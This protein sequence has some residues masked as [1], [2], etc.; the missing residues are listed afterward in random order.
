MA[1]PAFSIRPL[2]DNDLPAVLDVYRGCEDFLAL[3]PVATASLAMVQQDIAQS[4]EMGGTFCGI[5]APDEIMLGVVDYVLSGFECDPRHAFIS[6]LMIA[7]P[8]RNMGLGAAVVAR[9]EAAIRLQPQVDA[10]LSGVQVNNPGAIRFWQR[11]GYTITSEAESMP[12][13]TTVYHLRK[14]LT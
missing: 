9:V 3:G 5:F 13:G 12:D 4:V 11:M 1:D 7:Q 8:Y 14:S 10:I 6:L 2:T